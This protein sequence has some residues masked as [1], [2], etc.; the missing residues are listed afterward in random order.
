[1]RLSGSGGC[2]GWD[3]VVSTAAADQPSKPCRVHAAC[4]FLCLPHNTNTIACHRALATPLLHLSRKPPPA[5]TSTASL[6]SPH[7]TC[8]CPAL[9]LPCHTQVTR[10][11]STTIAGGIKAIIAN[12]GVSRAMC[13]CARLLC[14]PRWREAGLRS[15]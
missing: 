5:H 7:S 10:S 13:S 1:M 9:L 4:R 8:R 15:G 14:V 11:R 12:E 3:T 6:M 2:Q